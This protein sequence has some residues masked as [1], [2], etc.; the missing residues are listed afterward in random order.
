MAPINEPAGASSRGMP[1]V[2]PETGIDLLLRQIA[3]AKEI[4]RFRPVLQVNYRH[5][6]NTTKDFLERAFGESRFDVRNFDE[7]P[8]YGTVNWDL[9]KWSVFYAER[10]RG[11][12]RALEGYVKEL[13]IEVK[14]QQKE[15][16][17]VTN[18]GR[19][20]SKKVFI[21]RP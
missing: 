12:I 19:G 5:W 9:R 21:S 2:K 8:V 16:S 1:A 11:R 3:K 7:D 20:S 14:N 18:V 6:H 13:Q 4:L 15:N 17:M 10:L